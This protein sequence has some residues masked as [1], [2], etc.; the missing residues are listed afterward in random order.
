L[1][2]EVAEGAARPSPATGASGVGGG[3]A[4]VFTGVGGAGVRVTAGVFVG[5]AVCVGLLG[6]WRHGPMRKCA[7]VP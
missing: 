6:R 2:C 4:T 1:N 7:A 5:V 3:G